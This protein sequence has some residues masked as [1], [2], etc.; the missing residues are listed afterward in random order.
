M[1]QVL[2]RLIGAIP[3]LIGVVLLIFL[4]MNIG[5]VR[6]IQ[7]SSLLLPIKAASFPMLLEQHPISMKTTLW[8]ELRLPSL[9]WTSP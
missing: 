4:M 8:E 7:I 5:N 3:V 9:K 1:K 6:W 2:K